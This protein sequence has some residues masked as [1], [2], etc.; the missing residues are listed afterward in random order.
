VV[1]DGV[2]QEVYDT[3]NGDP[4]WKYDNP[5]SAAKDFL[6]ENDNFILEEPSFLFN[7]SDL[8]QRITHWPNAFLKRK[9]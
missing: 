4:K 6:A 7:E 1:T 3:P 5:L 8:T 9:K 2:M